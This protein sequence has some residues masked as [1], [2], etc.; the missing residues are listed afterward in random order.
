MKIITLLYAMLLCFFVQSMSLAA[1]QATFGLSALNNNG[2]SVTVLTLYPTLGVGN[3]KVGLDVNIFLPS[4]AKPKSVPYVL[5]HYIEYDDGFSGIRYGIMDGITLG[6]GLIMN[7]YSSRV[8]GTTMFDPTQAGVKAYTNLYKPYGVMALMTHSQIYAGRLTYQPDMFTLL[9]RPIVLGVSYA[10][11]ND[12]VK[13]PTKTYGKGQA[14]MAADI[15]CELLGPAAILFSEY[16]QLLNHN[17]GL[18]AGLKG[19]LVGLFTYQFDYRALGRNFIPA[20]FGYQYEVQPV[21]LTA[22]NIG[23]ISGYHGSLGFS[24]GQLA[25]LKMEYQNLFFENTGK[26][27]PSLKAELVTQEIANF[28]V[29][30]RYEQ[31]QLRSLSSVGDE[32]ANIVVDTMVPLAMLGVPFPGKT[33]VSWKRIY[34]SDSPNGKFTDSLGFGYQY[35]LPF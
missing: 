12:G 8:N 29:R 24:L 21:D 15:G 4:D 28:T 17:G 6:Y 13:T 35:V 7:D 22:I 16:G 23:N 30:A 3:W 2:S 25:D 32:G 31:L 26:A 27:N 1:G 19:R 18:M 10:V 14:A 9:G 33:N 20:Y 34:S 5:F 11:D